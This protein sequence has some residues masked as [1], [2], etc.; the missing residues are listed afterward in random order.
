LAFNFDDVLPGPVP[1]NKPVWNH[2]RWVKIGKTDP[3]FHSMAKTQN[4][5]QIRAILDL[6]PDGSFLAGGAAAALVDP[7]HP[8]DDVDVWTT[9]ER[10][11]EIM[12]ALAPFGVK[13]ERD[14][15]HVR[16]FNGET[17]T[18][19]VIDL[20]WPRTTNFPRMQLII[21]PKYDTLF[22]VIDSF[23][24][25]VCQFGIGGGHIISD[26]QIY[27]NRGAYAS[28][29]TKV[30]VPHHII[31]AEFAAKRIKQYEDKGFHLP[32]DTRE[33]I[34]TSPVTA[35]RIYEGPSR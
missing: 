32:D 35:P 16:T 2:D 10:Y 18:V 13:A 8:Y 6:I 30:L 4:N 14:V 12:R 19:R 25:T 29:T 17:D 22:N 33:M 15:S 31:P 28:L 26:S 7:Y 34:L 20:V 1:V 9:P 5:R 3:V 24:W 27:A 21:G 23:D 11:V